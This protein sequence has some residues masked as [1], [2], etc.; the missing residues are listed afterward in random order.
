MHFKSLQEIVEYTTERGITIGQAVKEGEARLL[1]VPVKEVEERMGKQWQVMQEAA[2]LGIEKPKKSMGGLIGGEGKKLNDY[3][4]QQNTLAG[5]R[6]NLAVSRALAVAEVNAG[7]GKIVAAPTA[8]SCGIMPAVLLTVQE[9]VNASEEKVIDALFAASGIG[10][11]IAQKASIS[12]AEGGCQAECG[13]AAGMAAAAAVEIAGGT[14]AQVI[15]ACALA[16]KNILGLVCDP[17]AGLVEVPCAKRNALGTSLAL[18][19][20]DMALAGITSVIPVDE[21]ITA[22]G[23]VGRHLP[24]SLRETSQ[25]GLAATPTGK[26]IAKKL[27]SED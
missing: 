7:M 25:G 3:R 4:L 23:E 15:E 17:V 24:E 12:G 16:L 20:A 2:S 27:R 9:V 21:V 8:G 11:I 19:S 5:D 10:I 22:L 13:S 18:V 26:K 6:I 1:E 14:P